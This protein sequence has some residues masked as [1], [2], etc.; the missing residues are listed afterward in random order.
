MIS[1]R[2]WLGLSLGA[3]ATLA[4]TP[5]LLRALQQSG[6][7]LIQRAIPSSGEMLPAVGLSFSNH[8]GCADHAAL[9]EVLKA[10]ADGGGRVFDA[11]HVNPASEQV[12]ITAASELGLQSK[13]LW[14]TPGTP[15]HAAAIARI[16]G[17][18]KSVSP[19]RETLMTK[20]E[21]GDVIRYLKLASR[22]RRGNRETKV[23]QARNARRSF[24][25]ISEP[26]ATSA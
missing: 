17:V 5:E 4:L 15:G 22:I 7:K 18:A 19:M 8:P 11:M 9:K 6:G 1:R 14:S 3:G 10:F 23:R 24:L 16:A 13:L 25:S 12:H 20:T 2:E 26:M 21:A